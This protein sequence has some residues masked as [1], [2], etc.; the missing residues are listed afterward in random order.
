MITTENG[1]VL[2]QHDGLMFYTIGQRQG[3]NIADKKKQFSRA[4]VCFEKRYRT[5]YLNCRAKA[6]TIQHFFPMN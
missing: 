2:G 4:L 1:T 6:Q 5:Q 3:L